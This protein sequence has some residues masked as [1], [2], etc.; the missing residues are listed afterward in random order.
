MGSDLALECCFHTKKRR[1]WLLLFSQQ[2]WSEMRKHF[3]A[4]VSAQTLLGTYTRFLSFGGLQIWWWRVSLRMPTR[5]LDSWTNPSLNC[6]QDVLEH[7]TMQISSNT[8]GT[9]GLI[10]IL[11]S[12]KLHGCIQ[13]LPWCGNA[14]GSCHGL[15]KTCWNGV[16]TTA[17][18]RLDDIRCFPI[19]IIISY[20]D[21]TIYY[22][23]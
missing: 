14:A 13:Q 5:R 4:A 8:F 1:N 10:P 22:Y 17:E 7:C 15:T 20:I 2:I 21:I 12:L 11:C 3:S 18:R 9:P 23:M 16:M 6:F 19:W